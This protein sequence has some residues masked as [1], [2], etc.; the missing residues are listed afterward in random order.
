MNFITGRIEKPLEVSITTRDGKH[1]LRVHTKIE[2]RH[3]GSEI[4]IGI[5]PEKVIPHLSKKENCIPSLLEVIEPLGEIKILTVKLDG[6][7]LKVVTSQ[8]IKADQ[9]QVIWLEFD[10]RDIHAFHRETETTLIE[11]P[12]AIG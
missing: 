2:D 3:V 6:T 4:T 8:D 10:S 5:R 9:G 7:E 1:A 11:S 12:R